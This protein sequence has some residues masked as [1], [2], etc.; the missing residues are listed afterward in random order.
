MQCSYLISSPL[1]NCPKNDCVAIII[2]VQSLIKDQ[3]FNYHVLS[4]VALIF[5]P[6]C[7]AKRPK[8]IP[9]VVWRSEPNTQ[10]GKVRQNAQKRKVV[11]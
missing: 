6:K 3:A 2:L 8:S 1:S 5:K 11:R 7:H 4:L 9:E 10:K